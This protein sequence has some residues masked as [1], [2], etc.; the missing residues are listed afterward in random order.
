MNDKLKIIRDKHIA[1]ECTCEP[2]YTKRNLISPNCGYCNLVDYVVAI[3]SESYQLGRSEVI[4]EILESDNAWDLPHT[5]AKL[6]EATGI[7]MD[8]RDYDGDGWE[9]ITQAQMRGVAFLTKLN[10]LKETK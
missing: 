3:Q 5:L 8:K 7:L 2:Y 6:L 1:Q 9:Q 10:Q 4:E